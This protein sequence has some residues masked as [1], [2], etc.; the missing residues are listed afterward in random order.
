VRR[1]LRRRRLGIT[2]PTGESERVPDN[3]TIAFA[4]S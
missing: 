3:R 4:D 1:R 2:N